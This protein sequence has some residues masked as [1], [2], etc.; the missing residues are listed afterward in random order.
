M[1]GLLMGWARLSLAKAKLCSVWLRTG[2]NVEH[3][4]RT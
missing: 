2:Y 1:A 3:K 4:Y